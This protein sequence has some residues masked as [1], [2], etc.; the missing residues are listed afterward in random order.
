[1]GVNHR[2]PDIG[3][4]QQ[5]LNGADVVVGLQEMGGET[6]AQERTEALAMTITERQVFFAPASLSGALTINKSNNGEVMKK[7]NYFSY[8]S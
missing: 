8:F 4:A 7:H 3:V 5:G 1:M 2:G 6:V